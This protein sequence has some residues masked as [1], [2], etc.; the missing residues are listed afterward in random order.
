MT[1]LGELIGTLWFLVKSTVGSCCEVRW[2]MGWRHVARAL[3]AKMGDGRQSF[4]SLFF[5]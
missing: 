3:W 1:A 2:G 4:S 5:E